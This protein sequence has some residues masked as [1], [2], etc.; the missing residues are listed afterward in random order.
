MTQEEYC[1]FMYDEKNEF[2]CDCCPE[3]R[4]ME[5]GSS[6]VHPCGQQNCWV[7]IHCASADEG[8]D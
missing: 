8:R 7:T 5:S 1:K 3:N 2:N 6:R 4:D